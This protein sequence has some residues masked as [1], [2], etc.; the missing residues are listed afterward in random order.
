[1]R[2]TARAIA[3]TAGVLG[4]WTVGMTAAGAQTVDLHAGVPSNQGPRDEVTVLSNQAPP[5]DVTNVIATAET[6]AVAAPAPAP[7][8]PTSSALPV[9]GSDVIAI[10]GLGLGLVATGFVLKR[11]YSS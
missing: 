10:T 1:M 8:A 11:R 7:P 9:T 6:E 4:L 5:Q 2:S 3:T